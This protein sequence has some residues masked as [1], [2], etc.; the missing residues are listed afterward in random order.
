MH[1]ATCHGEYK[2]FWTDINDARRHHDGLGHGP[3][4]DASNRLNFFVFHNVA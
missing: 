1:G 4:Y 2:A 3:A